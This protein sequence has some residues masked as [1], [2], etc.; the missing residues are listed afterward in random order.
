MKKLKINCAKQDHKLA[1]I[2]PFDTTLG[3]WTSPLASLP[4]CIIF[5][6]TRS[7]HVV[8]L[9]AREQS[10]PTSA[11]SWHHRR[12]EQRLWFLSVPAPLRALS[13][14]CVVGKEKRYQWKMALPQCQPQEYA[15]FTNSTQ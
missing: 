3:R 2:L 8:L 11:K 5:L 14:G 4:F 12:R 15:G 9:P 1:G 6:P 13:Q 7:P 10:P